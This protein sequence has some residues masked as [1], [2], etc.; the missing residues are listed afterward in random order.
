M[1]AGDHDRCR[2]VIPGILDAAQPAACTETGGAAAGVK[3]RHTWETLTPYVLNT[4]EK[5]H[6]QHDLRLSGEG[7]VLWLPVPQPPLVL[8]QRA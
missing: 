1:T 8:A 6:L 3:H 4:T 7:V 2:V 5:D